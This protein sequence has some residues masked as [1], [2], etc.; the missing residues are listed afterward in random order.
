M[1]S[2]PVKNVEQ[3]GIKMGSVVA[4]LGSGSGHYTIAALRAVGD[5][6]KV[7]AIDIQKDMLTRVKNEAQN[8]GLAHIEVIWGD[9]EKSMGTRMKD[10]VADYAIISNL[11]FQIEDKKT[12]ASETFRIIKKGGKLLVVDWSESFGGIGPHRESVFTHDIAV[13][14][15][16]NAGFV[17]E[18]EIQA[19][20]H[21]YG[22][23]FLKP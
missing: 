16:T 3:F 4:D 9:I 22:I 2:D 21:H 7:Y 23:I 12:V 6:G 14:T 15:F 10:A 13:S 18:K 17:A 5:K 8:Q 19:G 20:E 11:M 1:F